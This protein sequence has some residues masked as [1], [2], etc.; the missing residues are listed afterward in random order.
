MTV[1]V[2]VDATDPTPPYEQ[3][4]TQL[5]DLIAGGVLEAGSRLSPVRQLAADLGLATGTVARAYRELE[6]GGFVTTRRG[7]GTT[8]SAD[9][10]ALRPVD[11]ER[12]V[13]AILRE[14]VSQARRVG[15]TEAEIQAALDRALVDRAV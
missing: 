1:R 14:A 3:L 10:P 9:A 11:R 5:A 15:A 4:R 2:R 6:A 8:V 13:E 12:R 7:G